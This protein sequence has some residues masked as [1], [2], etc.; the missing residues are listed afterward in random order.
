VIECD[1]VLKA[2]VANVALPLPLRAPVPNVAAPSMNVTVPAGT[3]VFPLGPVTDAVNVTC[4][5][6]V[7]GFCDDVTV[8]VVAGRVVAFTTCESTGEV[9]PA[10]LE[11]PKYTAVSE[12]NP[13]VNDEVV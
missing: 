1:P 5:P 11:S 10:K 4:C 7:D 2:D 3:V 9:D 12:C 13:V 6:A 8:V